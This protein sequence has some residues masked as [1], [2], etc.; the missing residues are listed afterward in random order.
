M[1]PSSTQFLK[2]ENSYVIIPFSS[3]TIQSITDSCSLDLETVSQINLAF[4]IPTTT[5]LNKAFIISH[6][7]H[8]INLPTALPVLLLIPSNQ[9]STLTISFPLP[10]ENNQCVT[11]P[12]GWSPR[13]LAWD[14]EFPSAWLQLSLQCH[15]LPHGLGSVGN[16]VPCT[17]YV[18]PLDFAHAVLFAWNN[19]THPSFA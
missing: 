1:V 2:L 19:T 11:S 9:S 13:L 18:M 6:I 10:A 7:N 3:L 4:S 14:L 5:S 12:A 15:F 8:S 16:H 17:H